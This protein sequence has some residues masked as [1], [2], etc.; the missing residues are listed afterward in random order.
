VAAVLRLILDESLS[1]RVLLLVGG[2]DPR[3]L[4]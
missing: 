3:F 4:C 2:A 1:G